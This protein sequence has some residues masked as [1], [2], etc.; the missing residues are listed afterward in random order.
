MAGTKDSVTAWIEP[1]PPADA[2]AQEGS[3]LM[4]AH[5]FALRVVWN[6]E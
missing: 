6:F 1:H 2:G 5:L 3:L 4:T